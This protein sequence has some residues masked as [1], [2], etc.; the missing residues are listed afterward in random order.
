MAVARPQ[1]DSP[2]DQRETAGGRE[3]RRQAAKN[4]VCEVAESPARL[5]ERRRAKLAA[6][7][8]MR[9]SEIT[10]TERQAVRMQR[11]VPRK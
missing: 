9:L 10:G 5:R 7:A 11:P 4:S 1:A 8:S 6:A 2:K 3:L